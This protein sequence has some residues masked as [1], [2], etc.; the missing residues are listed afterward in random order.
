MWTRCD[1]RLLSALKSRGTVR[2]TN[3]GFEKPEHGDMG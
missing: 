1:I 3:L 2:E